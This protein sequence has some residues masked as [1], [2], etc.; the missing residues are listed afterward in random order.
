MFPI[1]FFHFSQ[2]CF[3]VSEM[4]SSQPFLSLHRS[5]NNSFASR[6]AGATKPS[7]SN[8][9]ATVER[10]PRRVEGFSSKRTLNF[11]TSFSTS[12]ATPSALSSGNLSPISKHFTVFARLSSGML[13]ITSLSE[14]TNFVRL[15][16]VFFKRSHAPLTQE[17]ASSRLST[18]IRK[19]ST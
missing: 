13:A 14:Q 16:P 19:S 17:T 6:R 5:C 12:Q 11:S 1:D 8:K 3:C 18:E 2:F 10:M 7:G 15:N 9:E 4:G